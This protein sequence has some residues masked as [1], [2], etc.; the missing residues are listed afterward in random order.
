MFRAVIHPSIHP[1]EVDDPADP[2]G[3]QAR[4]TNRQWNWKMSTVR[5]EGGGGGAGGGGGGGQEPHIISILVCCSAHCVMLGFD[6]HDTGALDG[7]APCPFC[8]LSVVHPCL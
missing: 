8:S 7:P 2:M 4:G 6:C 3:E 5:P 1:V